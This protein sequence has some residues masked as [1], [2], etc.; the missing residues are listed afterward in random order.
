[1]LE[2]VTVT[3]RRGWDCQRQGGARDWSEVVNCF[4]LLSSILALIQSTYLVSQILPGENRIKLG[5]RI[6]FD[7]NQHPKRLYRS[8]KP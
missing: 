6:R 2:V 8:I 5:G 7:Q 4:I 1:M 3:T